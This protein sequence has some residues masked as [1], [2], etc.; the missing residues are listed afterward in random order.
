MK[1]ISQKSMSFFYSIVI[2]IRPFSFH[3]KIYWLKDGATVYV[4]KEELPSQRQKSQYCISITINFNK[5]IDFATNLIMLV[6]KH[7][8]KH[9]LHMKFLCKNKIFFSLLLVFIGTHWRWRECKY[10]I[11]LCMHYMQIDAF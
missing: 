9:N 1:L 10:L 2:E 8:E 5:P 4:N 6:E 11:H 3:L 7:K